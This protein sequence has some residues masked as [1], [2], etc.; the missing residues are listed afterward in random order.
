MESPGGTLRRRYRP[1]ASEIDDE[2]LN[3]GPRAMEVDHEGDQQ[4]PDPRDADW[5]DLETSSWKEFLRTRL[6]AERGPQMRGETS[7]MLR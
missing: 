2:N 5:W 4:E 3:Y 6:A 7:S 1:T